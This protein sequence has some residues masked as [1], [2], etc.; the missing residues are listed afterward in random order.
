[1]FGPH[2]RSSPLKSFLKYKNK[3]SINY[4]SLVSTSRPIHVK[5]RQGPLSYW[6]SRAAGRRIT[7]IVQTRL[8]ATRVARFVVWLTAANFRF[9]APSCTMTDFCLCAHQKEQLDA[10]QSLTVA[11][12]AVPLAELLIVNWSVNWFACVVE[13]STTCWGPRPASSER[14]TCTPCRT[15]AAI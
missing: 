14:S 5:T 10:K 6:R 13:H 3:R 11:R 4:F 12:S 2:A 15:Y 9:S 1:M 8:I 7:C